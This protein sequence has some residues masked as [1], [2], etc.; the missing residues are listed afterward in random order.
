MNSWLNHFEN[1]C[2][3]KSDDLSIDK[4]R[5][6]TEDITID[7]LE[8]DRPFLNRVCM[9][10]NV[11][12]EMVEH[13]LELYPQAINTCIEYG[14]D[15]FEDPLPNPLHLACLNEDCPKEVILLLLRKKQQHLRKMCLM[16]CTNKWNNTDIDCDGPPGGTPI[17]YY[18]TR[19]S[20][21]DLDIVK[22]LVPN[23]EMLQSHDGDTKCTP[24]NI[25]MHNK[26]IGEMD[27]V[28]QYLA[29]TNPSSLLVKNRWEETPLHIACKN[30]HITASTIRI[31]LK[32]CPETAR[33]LNHYDELPIHFV[34]IYKSLDL[35]DK[36]NTLPLCCQDI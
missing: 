26:K 3:S 11:T 12:L 32:A 8:E 4:L 34:K 36:H 9:N 10:K 1:F 33:Q 17:H 29:E 22:Q 7:Y 18:L 5:R 31:L 2:Q 19:S 14:N 15:G 13:L 35:Y 30:E 23:P 21:I 25:F 24:I 27:D 28:L 6:M 16:Y 20:N